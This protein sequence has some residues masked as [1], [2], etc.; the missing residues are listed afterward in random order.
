[1]ATAESVTARGTGSS[2]IG[3]EKLM[4]DLRMLAADAE[5]LVKATANSSG[6]QIAAARVKAEESLAAAKA[7][8]AVTQ[9]AIVEK[10]KLAA[11][12]GDDYVRENPWRAIGIAAALGAIVGVLITRR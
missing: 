4:Q 11:K 10:G 8:L 3:R 6:Q 1:M 9:A 2:E 7:R 5:E 12:A